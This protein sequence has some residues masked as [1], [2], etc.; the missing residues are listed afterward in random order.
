MPRVQASKWIG[1]RLFVIE[2]SS[3]DE[4][5]ITDCYTEGQVITFV[6]VS[7]EFNFYVY[8]EESFNHGSK[9]RGDGPRHA[10]V[11]PLA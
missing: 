11:Y 3:R 5:V 6:T 2:N 4:G 8:T 1:W 9:F 10:E 7:G